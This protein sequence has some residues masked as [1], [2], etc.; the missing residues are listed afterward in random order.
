MSNST[1]G[2]TFQMKALQSSKRLHLTYSVLVWFL[3]IKFY[4]EGLLDIKVDLITQMKLNIPSK[5]DTSGRPFKGFDFLSNVPPLG[6]M[7]N[8]CLPGSHAEVT[9]SPLTAYWCYPL[10][11][12]IWLPTFIF[13]QNGRTDSCHW[14]T[15]WNSR[16]PF[17]DLNTWKKPAVLQILC[18]GKKGSNCRKF[19]SLWSRL[20]Q[21]TRKTH[22]LR[23]NACSPVSEEWWSALLAVVSRPALTPKG[24][25]SAST[26]SLNA[27]VGEGAKWSGSFMRIQ[28]SFHLISCIFRPRLI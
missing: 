7:F 2:Y 5:Y 3:F 22:V 21:Q 28:F 20:W 4:F 6:Q 15:V 8:V 12:H 14:N 13:P 25:L 18:L 24:F 9:H 27:H 19:A 26:P 1:S 11:P 23:D 16:F 10:C 17:P